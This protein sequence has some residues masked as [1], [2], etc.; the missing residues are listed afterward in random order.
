MLGVVEPVRT[1]GR[2]FVAAR[3]PRLRHQGHDRV[4]GFLLRQQQHGG[5]FGETGRQ[6]QRQRR[7][8]GAAPAFERNRQPAI[9]RLQD[10][11][12]DRALESGVVRDEQTIRIGGGGFKLDRQR[13]AGRQPDLH[14]AIVDRIAAAQDFGAT[15]AG[16]ILRAVLAQ[17]ELAAGFEID[18]DARSGCHH[19]PRAGVM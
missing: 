6:R 12:Q 2:V 18:D 14:R 9:A 4:V 19:C 10:V 11:V 8:H 15:I 1:G 16:V 7:R 13:R 17:S 3:P 5:D